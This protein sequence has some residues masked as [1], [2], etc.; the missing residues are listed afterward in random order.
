[1][2]GGGD[3]AQDRLIPDV[4]R[5]LDAGVTLLVRSPMAT[6]PWQHVLE[7]LSGYLLLAERLLA[8]HRGGSRQILMISDGEPTAHLERGRSQIAD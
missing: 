2:I 5:A 6:R 1:M 7:P 4:L 8:K 3:W